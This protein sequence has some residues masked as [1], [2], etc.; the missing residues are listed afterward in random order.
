[1]SNKNYRYNSNDKFKEFD[2]DFEDYGYDVKNIR[3]Q[4][5]KKVTKFKTKDD[6]WY[7]SFWT[8]TLI[9]QITSGDAILHLLMRFLMLT[10][11][12]LDQLIDNYAERIV[13]E[14]DVKCLMQFVYDSIAENLRGKDEE[15]VLGEIAYVYDE[16]VIEELIESV[17]V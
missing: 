7:D 16:D 2:D 10:S 15:E 9:S 13:D 11:A 6:E 3:R 1:M 5:K 17:T 8:G 4:S 14:M 12:Q